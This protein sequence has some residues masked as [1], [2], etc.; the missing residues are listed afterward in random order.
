[1]RLRQAL[2]EIVVGDCDQVAQ[3]LNV[4]LFA[5]A[6]LHMTIALALAFEQPGGIREHCAIVEADIRMSLKRVD[7]S[8]RRVP[9]TSDRTSVVQE[10]ADIGAAAAHALKPRPRH[11]P[12]WIGEAGKPNLNSRIASDR[13]GEPQQIVHWPALTHSRPSLTFASRAVGWLALPTRRA[14]LR[15]ADRPHGC[16]GSACPCS[17]T[18]QEGQ[19]GATCRGRKP[20]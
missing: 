10:L 11:Q 7:I 13:T 2:P 6:Q 14:A 8:K 15:R 12:E 3:S 18:R 20:L 19:E 4:Q 1:M 17:W 16:R 9:H 5:G